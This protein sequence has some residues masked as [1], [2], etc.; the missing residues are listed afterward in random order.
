V[1]Q[2]YGVLGA[3]ERLLVE[4]GAPILKGTGAIFDGS[5]ARRLREAIRATSAMANAMREFASRA[6]SDADV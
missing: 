3:L 2:I 5:E 4:L 6:H 1:R